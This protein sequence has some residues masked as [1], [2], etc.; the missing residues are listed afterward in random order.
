M[1][2]TRAKF[3]RLSYNGDF[4]LV[5]KQLADVLAEGDHRPANLT[6]DL[7]LSRFP[8]D[9]VKPIL[10]EAFGNWVRARG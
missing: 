6:L 3:E 10:E 5:A 8:I 9:M 1:G 7:F 2:R 4:G